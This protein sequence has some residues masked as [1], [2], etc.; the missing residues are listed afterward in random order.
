VLSHSL[1]KC[2][3]IPRNSQTLDSDSYGQCKGS[4]GKGNPREIVCFPIQ[5][6]AAA[7]VSPGYCTVRLLLFRR[8]KIQLERRR[9]NGED[10]VVD[11]ILTGLSTEMIEMVFV[12]W[13]NRF[14]HIIDGNG[15]CAS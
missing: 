13:M 12:D 2:S 8:L 5:T 11:E 3:Q 6:H 14:Q 9:Y 15:D 1:R 7:I 4:H 10:E